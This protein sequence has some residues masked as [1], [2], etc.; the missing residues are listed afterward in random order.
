MSIGDRRVCL[1]T[2]AGGLLGNEF[3]STYAGE[4]DILAVCKTRVPEVPSQ[5]ESYVDPL[6]PDVPYAAA[7]VYVVHADLCD[8]HD[9]ERVV[10]V[11]LARYGRVDLL[12]NN[13]A[14]MGRYTSTMIDGDTALI[15]LVQHMQ[16]NV[17]AP[18]RLSVRLAQQ[19]W[20]TRASENRAANR[21]IVNISS[22]AGS[23]VY[24]FQG[25]A[26]YAASKAAFDALSGHMAAEFDSFGVRVNVVAPNTFPALVS[27]E[28][29]MEAVVELDRGT[30]TG[31]TVMIDI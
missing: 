30:A 18:L 31:S 10:D 15:D 11:A 2:G 17:I 28:S 14:Y 7:S 26:G 16:T 21:N 24:P 3:C 9:V 8:I 6:E 20:A 12:V 19:F 13:A 27:T 25:Q 22:T 23:K 29:V 1:L 5:Y 4:Y